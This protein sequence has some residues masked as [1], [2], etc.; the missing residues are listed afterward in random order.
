M[1]II[2][3]CIWFPYLARLE[4]EISLVIRDVLCYL[5]LYNGRNSLLRGIKTKLIVLVKI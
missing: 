1:L 5:V 2:W 3:L 4:L